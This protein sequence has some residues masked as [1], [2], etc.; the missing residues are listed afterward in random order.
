MRLTRAKDQ[1]VSLLPVNWLLIVIVI[2][3]FLSTVTSSSIE[4]KKINLNSKNKPNSSSKHPPP[5]PPHHAIS[6]SASAP[7]S[8][9]PNPIQDSVIKVAG[10]LLASDSP[11]SSSSSSSSSPGQFTDKSF[12]SCPLGW[13]S[14]PSLVHYD[15][16]SGH[17]LID[18]PYRVTDDLEPSICI[19]DC[20]RDP[21]CKSLN[22]DYKRGTCEFIQARVRESPLIDS[23]RLPTQFNLL[24]RN[25]L[26][27]SP[28][29]NY[30][31]KICLNSTLCP[32]KDWSFERVKSS[33]LSP[34]TFDGK[35]SNYNLT[36]IEAVI[37]R[38]VC[39]TLCL[40][41]TKFTCRAAIYDQSGHFCW[42]S[43]VNRFSSPEI[44]LERALNFEYFESNCASEAR[45]FCNTKGAKDQKQLLSERILFTST[46]EECQSECIL[47]SSSSSSYSTSTSSGGP[48]WSGHGHG[49][50][51][52]FNWTAVH[53]NSYLPGLKKPSDTQHLL[54]PHA[55]SKQHPSSSSSSSSSSAS[56][57]GFICRSFSYEASSH[58]CSLS[59]HSSRTSLPS[60]IRSPGYVYFELASCF[61]GECRGS[62]CFWGG[63]HFHTRG[64]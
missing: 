20:T 48:I 11:A 5:P 59:H 42:L 14:N 56:T 16:I 39:L 44:K 22:I 63:G 41:E 37:S 43:S 21:D 51:S 24:K 31:E 8:I 27:P 1:K 62:F 64:A 34:A 33:K 12:P 9:S 50:G 58:T 45:G 32:A 6:S 46:L 23:T 36:I 47:S 28:G 25:N 35:V 57:T 17:Y 61:D 15:L 13:E 19:R 2:N 30:F 55:P 38:E 60:L 29:Q 40:N 10:Q 54:H 26:R 52:H 49:H 53:V 4:G 7:S 18:T 3:L